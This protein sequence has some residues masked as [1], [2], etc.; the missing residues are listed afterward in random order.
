MFMNNVKKIGLWIFRLFPT[1]SSDW[2]PGR[3]LRM[4]LLFNRGVDECTRLDDNVD[5]CIIYEDGNL[6]QGWYT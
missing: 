1:G 4:K 6:L 3:A 5:L 2:N